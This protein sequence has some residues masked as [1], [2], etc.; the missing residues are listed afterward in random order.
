MPFANSAFTNSTFFGRPFALRD[1]RTIGTIGEAARFI[2]EIPKNGAQKLHWRVAANGL[3]EAD[4][5]PDN[6]DLLHTAI[7]A[8]KNA[9]Q[10]DDLLGS[11]LAFETCSKT[12][13]LENLKKAGLL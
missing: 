12:V 5:N 4:R 10:T 13:A 3:K 11:R 1:G 6:L 7:R 2:A 8:V 9:L